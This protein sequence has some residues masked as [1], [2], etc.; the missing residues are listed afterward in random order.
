MLTTERLTI[1]PIE[2]ADWPAVRDIWAGCARSPYSQFVQPHSTAPD[3]VCACIAQWAAL[4]AAGTEHMYLAV[5]LNGAVIGYCAVHA[6]KRGHEIGYGFHPLFQG[7]GY[8]SEALRAVVAHLQAQSIRRIFACTALKN[9]PS[10]R[11]LTALGF[12][13]SGT[14]EIS[15]CKDE[16]GHD[17]VIQDGVFELEYPANPILLATERLTIRPIEAADWPAIRDVWA[18]LAPLPMAQY[19]K[20]FNTDPEQ[21]RAR[22]ARWAEFT[23][24]GT[25]HMFFAACLAG[26]VIGYMAFNIREN[27]H[28]VGYSFHPAHHGNGYAK[29]A[30][31]ALLVHLR[32]LGITC[33]TA[34]TAL[35]NT[36][37]VRLLTGL[38]FRLTGT[39]QVSF[40]KDETGEDIVFEGGIFELE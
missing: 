9:T 18:A 4:T 17:I 33:F 2:A 8:A 38:G 29:E 35:N 22:I 5:C 32:G 25:E 26:E 14:R 34:G 30:L 6:R 37:S 15:F 12:R 7:K 10:V 11:L 28:E 36:P 20:P 31:K 24:K 16:N 40:Y 13:Q 23:A 1:R 27:G 21:V 39:E 3:D 19:D